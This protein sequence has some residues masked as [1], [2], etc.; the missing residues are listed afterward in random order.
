M[1]LHLTI[2]NYT[3]RGH[4]AA[5]ITITLTVP[6]D[7]GTI[8][9]LADIM[10]KAFVAIG[11]P[12]DRIGW[13]EMI[14]TVGI[15]LAAGRGAGVTGGQGARIIDDDA[16]VAAAQEEPGHMNGDGGG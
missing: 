16:G 13:V 10:E 9:E 12:P 11:G 8:M 2:K 7:T 14:H 5:E 3:D 15:H 4:Y 1:T 6:C